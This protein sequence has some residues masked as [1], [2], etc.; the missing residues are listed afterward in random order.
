MNIV[1]A[2][3]VLITLVTGIPVLI[4]LLRGHPRGLD[5]LF[6][7]RDVGA[8]LLLRTCRAILIFY[9]TQHFLFDPKSPTRP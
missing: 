5:H 6:P 4:Q 3:G 1:I 2:A 7:G 9:L 8:V